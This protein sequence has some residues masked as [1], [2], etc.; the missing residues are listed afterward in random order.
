MAD[1]DPKKELNP[2]II[3]G[4]AVVLVLFAFATVGYIVFV[5]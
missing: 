5:S 1:Y 4:G 3:L 2:S